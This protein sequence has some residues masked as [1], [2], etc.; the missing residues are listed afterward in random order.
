[1]RTGLLALGIAA[2]I[3]AS[4][5]AFAQVVPVV[6][7]QREL[8]ITPTINMTYDT[9]VGRTQESIS[10][11]RG[12]NPEDEIVNPSLVFE[13]VQ[14][15]GRQAAFLQGFAGYDYHAENR[16]LNHVNA[17]VSGGGLLTVGPCHTTGYGQFTAV[18]SDLQDASLAVTKNLSETST[19]GGQIICGQQRGFNAQLM[20]VYSDVVNSETRQKVADHRG[21][22]ISLQVGYANNTLGNIGLV[23]TYAE[24][25]YPS[26]QNFDGTFGDSYWNELLGVSYQRQFG[27]KLKVQAQVGQSLLKRAQAQPGFPQKI[28][29]TNYTALVDYK[30]SS[31]LEFLLQGARQFQPSNR[32]GK[33]VDL[34]T[35]VDGSGAYNLGTRITVTLAGFWEEM[36]ANQDTSANALPTFTQSHTTGEDLSIRYRQ[37]R[38]LTGI[39]DVRHEDRDT[40]LAVFNYSDT[41]VTLTLS[42]SF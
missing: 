18:Q 30:M 20:G 37:S 24:Q 7:N 19:G 25:K 10:R 15:I 21:N 42:S 11:L 9:N 5:P 4:G 36:K 22:Q 39:L 12:I 38:R 28:R 23:G 17:D 6:Q 8:K 16:I 26:R 27:S 31:R 1:M 29:G 13:V 41:R 32:P 34:V 2:G 33:L 35:R 40:D 3:A 14:P